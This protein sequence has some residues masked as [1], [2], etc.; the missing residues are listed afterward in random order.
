MAVK[1]WIIG[2]DAREMWHH[3]FEGMKKQKPTSIGFLR[4]GIVKPLTVDSSIWPCVFNDGH[5]P[6]LSDAEREKIGLGTVQLPEWTG[7]N[8]P[9]W[10]NLEKL[11][12]YLAEYETELTKPYWIIAITGLM[13]DLELKPIKEDWPRFGATN[14]STL[15][16][17]WQMVG[18]DIVTRW[19]ECS[20]TGASYEGSEAYLQ[21]LK[22]KWGLCLNE[23]H[24]FK[25]IDHALEFR[26]FE[27][28]RIPSDSPHFIHGIWLI[29]AVNE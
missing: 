4:D 12:K 28:D 16:T 14:P 15:D 20:L 9:L 17:S 21:S 6:R 10:E 25:D 18:Y 23:Y 29:R 2:Y 5:Y 27:N 24:L 1:E 13:Q 7:I 3:N 22:E 19:H 8:M 11:E 26:A